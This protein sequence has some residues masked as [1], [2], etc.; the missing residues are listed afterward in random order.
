MFPCAAGVESGNLR[1]QDTREVVLVFLDG[2]PQTLVKGPGESYF[3]KGPQG[4]RDASVCPPGFRYEGT[5]VLRWE[6][7]SG[8]RTG[9]ECE[10]GFNAGPVWSEDHLPTH[11]LCQPVPSWGMLLSHGNSVTA[12]PPTGKARSSPQ[13]S[14]VNHCRLPS[15]LSCAK[16]CVSVCVCVVSVAEILCLSLISFL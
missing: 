1:C 13:S 15:S 10:L 9:S 11:A 4:S 16:V 7:L 2:V 5:E 3:L 6:R 12:P 8:R 14:C